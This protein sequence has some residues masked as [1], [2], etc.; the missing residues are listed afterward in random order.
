VPQPGDPN[1]LLATTFGRGQFAIRLAPVIFP[2]T[3]Q[4]DTKLP[5]PAGSI[6]GKDSQNNPIVKIT[7]PVLDGL[8]EQ[9]AFGSVV[10]ITIVDMA[11][12]SNPRIIGGYNPSDP[13]TQTAANQTNASGNF[14]VQLNQG[15]FPTQGIKTIGIYATD[16]SGTRGNIQTI[17]INY[18]PSSLGLPQP[19]GAKPDDG[20]AELERERDLR[21]RAVPS[22]DGDDRVARADEDDVA[23]LV[24]AGDDRNR[25]PAIRIAPSEP[26]EQTHDDATHLGRAPRGRLHHAPQAAAEDDGPGASERGA[27]P[28]GVARHARGADAFSDDADVQGHDAGG[29]YHRRAAT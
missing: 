19:P 25:H 8:S 17:T 27:D 7:Q 4:L 1:I 11:D 6:S 9:S 16:L 28:L 29:V 15:A 23:R 24:H 3:V 26:G 13:S 10:R 2:G 12:P 18:Q 21:Q 14:S 5:A 22:P 20:D